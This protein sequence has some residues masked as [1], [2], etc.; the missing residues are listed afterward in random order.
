MPVKLPSHLH[1]NRFGTLYFRLAVPADLR[2]HFASKEIYRSL[3]T[4]SVRA[5]VP[6]AQALS[7]AARHV[8]EQLRNRTMPDQK[9]PPAAP[10][11]GF[12][13]GLITEISFDD[14]MR[15]KLTL[16]PEVGDTSEDRVQAQVEFLRATGLA[17]AGATVLKKRSPLFSELVND[18]KRDRLATEKWEESTQEENLAI[19]QLFIDIVGDMPIGD[20]SE[21]IAL[22]F[23]ETVKKLPANR[24]KMRAYKGKSIEEVI[25]LDPPPMAT[26]TINKYLERISSLFKFATSKPKYDLHYNPFSGRSLEGDSQRREPFTVDELIRLFSAGEHADH[27]YKADFHFWLPLLGLLTGARLNELC[28]LHLSDFEVVEGIPCINISDEEEGQRLKN[29]SAKRL[30]P[31]HDKLIEIGI[32]RFVEQRRN[33]GV[34]RLF[35]SLEFRNK[36]GYGATASKWFGNFKKRCGINE[37][38]TKVFHS[39]RHTFISSLLNDDVPET[40]IAPIVGHEGKLVTSTVYWNKKD[41][42]KRKAIIDKLQLPNDVWQ[43]VPIFEHVTFGAGQSSCQQ[44]FAGAAPVVHSRARNNS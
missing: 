31:L 1:R 19:Y 26:R 4:S 3:R 41:P 5:A 2:H 18:Y 21:E 30:V 15:P 11:D 7:Y 42:A 25:A 16:I 40:V 10:Y 39:F 44:H 20:V 35:P 33:Q 28:Q 34:E 23:V 37:K 17:G 27:H 13:L 32:L 9:K 8:F 24:N 6:A 29:K 36:G 12:E 38:N 43:L 14:L 22:T